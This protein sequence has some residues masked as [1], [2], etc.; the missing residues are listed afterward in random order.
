MKTISESLECDDQP[1]DGATIMGEKGK[2]DNGLET[3]STIR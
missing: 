1:I 2:S 3:F